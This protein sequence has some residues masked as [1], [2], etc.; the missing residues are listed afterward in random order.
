MQLRQPRQR[1]RFLQKKESEQRVLGRGVEAKEGQPMLWAV[2]PRLVLPETLRAERPRTTRGPAISTTGM[3]HNATVSRT[4][5][6]SS[7]GPSPSRGASE[8]ATNSVLKAELEAANAKTFRVEQTAD[9]VLK[10]P[11]LDLKR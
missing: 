2:R 6:V 8:S 1:N 3:N 9:S 4:L 5:R 7:E 10:H 11:N